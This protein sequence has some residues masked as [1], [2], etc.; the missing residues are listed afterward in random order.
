MRLILGVTADK[1]TRF[2][3]AVT[4]RVKIENSAFTCYADFFLVYP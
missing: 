3:V 1:K 4:A 2:E